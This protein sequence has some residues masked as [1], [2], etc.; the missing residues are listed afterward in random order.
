MRIP[1]LSSCLALAA[2][3]TPSVASEPEIEAQAS[4]YSADDEAE[5]LARFQALVE[6]FSKGVGLVSYD[7]TVAVKGAEAPSALPVTTRA[8]IAADAL[9]QARMAAATDNTT[10]LIV[11]RK[12]AIEAEHYFGD[13][14]ADMLLN[15]RS[16]AKPLTAIAIGRALELGAITSLDQRVADFIPE[17]R[18]DAQKSRILIR[19]LLDM[20]TGFL[21]QAAAFDPQH[22]LNRAYLHPRHDEVIIN[23]YPLVSKPGARYDYSNA[24]SEM[25][26]PV[27]E[28]ATG[29]QYEEF[30]STEV[31]TPIGA[32]GGEL[33]VNREG[34][35]AHSGCCI[36]LPARD[37]LRLSVLLLNDGVWQGRQLLPEGYVEA[38]RTPTAEN[39][40]YGMGVWVAGDFIAERGVA[41]PDR[42]EYTTLHSEAYRA[43]DLFLW[44]GNGNQVSY[45]VPSEDLVVLRMG[46]A[47]PKPTRWDN[48]RLPNLILGGIIADLGTSV[49]QA[50][51]Q[52]D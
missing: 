36:L 16:F 41:N 31:L 8:T 34:G 27:I 19:H 45:I 42:G 44:D 46:K 24:T 25:I 51:L 48:A 40:Y 3:M 6:S 47:P 13:T 35:M 7:P 2:C 14:N 21:P 5:H 18:G 52:Q 30:L 39:P 12:G 49:P 37:W 1:V 15:S 29:R 22:I 20:R 4:R 32:K 50:N 10:A 23:D 26:A 43:A 9:E 38:M 11:W 33:W 17:W 28:A